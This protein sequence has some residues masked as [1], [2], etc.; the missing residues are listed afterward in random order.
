MTVILYIMIVI[1]TS[2]Q[3]L[4]YLSNTQTYPNDSAESRDL[5]RISSYPYKHGKHQHARLPRTKI[6]LMDCSAQCP[7]PHKRCAPAALPLPPSKRHAQLCWPP[8]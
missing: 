8:Q 2:G 6:Y 5:L 3:N 7:C 1:P 4:K